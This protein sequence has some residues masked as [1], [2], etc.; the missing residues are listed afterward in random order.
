MRPTN[1]ATSLRH[2]LTAALLFALPVSGNA[3]GFELE[4]LNGKTHRLADY[5]GK[6][7]LVNFWASWCPPCLEEIPE[8]SSLHDAHKDKD[9][10]V[11]GIAMD[12]GSKFKVADFAQ[13]HG[14][15]YPVVMGNRGIAAGFGVIDTLPASY[16]YAPNGE[17]VS[18]HTGMVTRTGVEKYIKNRKFN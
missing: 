16:I 14:I 12:S 18:R 2:V 4:D 1:T 13:A 15:I 3:A 6:W 8:L 7:V 10:V 9:L 17:L 11:I 5:K